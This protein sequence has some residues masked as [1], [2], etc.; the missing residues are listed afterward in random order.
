MTVLVVMIAIAASFAQTTPGLIVQPARNGGEQ[1]LDPN[2]DNY[3]SS[4]STGF[5][6]TSDTGEG[7][8]EIPFRSI[9]TLTA[10]P[11]GDLKNGTAGSHTDFAPPSPLQAFY[12]GTNLIFRL[13]LGGIS[14][15]SRGYSVLIDS[16]NSFSGAG[17]NPG[18]EFEVLL[19]SNFGVSVIQH[20]GTTRQT[21][22]SGAATQFSQKAVAASTGGGD[23]DYFY[24]F[25]VPITA[26]NNLIS[27][28][29]P[30]RM[31]A[32]T[33]NRGQ[34]ALQDVSQVA[35]VAGVDFSRYNQDAPAAWADVIG[36]F[37]PLT[38]NNLVT[39]DIAQ[40]RTFAP[41]LNS[42]ITTAAT[43]IA[44][45][46]RE[47][48]G[49][50][51]QV[52]R[53]G[54]AIGTTTVTSEETWAFALPAGVTLAE[55]NQITA[56]A[57]AA[58]KPVSEAS[59]TVVV[60]GT[61]C[62]TAAPTLS[63]APSSRR[64]RDLTGT[65]APGATVRVYR[66][67]V[68]I[69]NTAGASSVTASST[70]AWTFTVCN[71]ANCISNGLYT[72]TQQVG[73]GCISAPS[74]PL[75][76]VNGRATQQPST[77]APTITTAPVCVGSSNLSGTATA[78]AFVTLF[79]N[80]RPLYLVTT[81]DNAYTVQANAAGA[82]T[83]SGDLGLAAGNTVFARAR[84][85]S[86]YYG[87]S[88]TVTVTSC[89]TTAPVITGEYCGTTTTVTGTS[90]ERAGTTIQIYAD[91]TAVG[92]SGTVNENGFWTVTGLAIPAGT[93]FT[94][95]ATAPG[96]TQSEDSEP[97]TAT[98]QTP[99]T[100]LTI[101]G[102]IQEAATTI[103]GTGPAGAQLTLYIAGTPFTPIVI[104][105]SG[106]WSLS[107]F[108]RSEVFAGAE[109]TATVTAAGQCE[110]EFAEAVVVDCLPLT[111]TFTLSSDSPATL[112]GGSGTVTI[113]LA[114]SQ[115]GVIYTILADG[116]ESGAAVLGTGGPI[117]ITS[118]PIVNETATARE[119]TLRVRASRLVQGTEAPAS[120]SATLDGSITRTILPQVSTDYE[121]VPLTSNIC[122][123]SSVNLQLSSSVSGYTYQ[124]LNEAT[125][126]LV[127]T[128]V[129][130]T[131][132]AISLSTGAVNFNATYAVVI[133][134]NDNGC[135]LTD[136]ARFT[137]VIT[138]PAIDR[139]V[140]ASASSVC[141][142]GPATIN[143]STQANAGYRYDI[144]QI[145]P[146]GVSTQ[147]ANDIEGTGG[148][149]PFTTTRPLD[150]EG[151][152]T[153]YVV[154][155]GGGCGARE[156]LQRASVEVTNAPGVADAGEDQRVCGSE[157]VLAAASPA[158]GTGSWSTVTQPA[159]SPA[160]VFANVNNPATSITGLVSGEYVFRWSVTTTCGGSTSPAVTDEVTITVNCPSTY[161]V[162]PPKYRDEYISGNPLATASD[163]DGGIIA[164]T[165]L[166]GS[167]P[168]GVAF[169][170]TNGNITV[171]EPEL[172]VPGLYEFSVRL[173][174][175]FGD[176]TELTVSILIQ[177]DSPAIVP[178]PVELVY[179]TASVSNGQVQLQWLT[180][181]EQDNDRFEV[182]RSLDAKSFEKIGTVK[183]QGT[184]SVENKY[185]F[186]DRAPAQGTV[187]YR[188]R[189]VDFSGEFAL[190]KVIAV[191]ADG[192]ASNLITEVYPNPF[193]DIL[194]VKL[195]SPDNKAADM[196]IYD[197]NGREVLRK[198]LELETG[199]NNLEL[200]LQQLE[201][202]M[203]ILK[204][205][206]SGLDATTRIMKN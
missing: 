19:N 189:Q 199:V 181:S 173:T 57:T 117:S 51:I 113:N 2:G 43:T 44:G 159:G 147:V 1:I 169:N 185:Q 156:V 120:C 133:T 135:V 41:V 125:G 99:V 174:D 69:T 137:A 176:E 8:S 94:A 155:T 198:A 91:G 184:S 46:S 130:G 186:S 166:S 31:A 143:V 172:L 168:P 89:Q 38:L 164:A 3:V 175:S 85:A 52:L 152:Y 16:D 73:E 93:P 138:G 71:S 7:N 84:T 106:E 17:A 206:G 124:L 183:G 190:S 178:L 177:E 134:N 191:T 145:D 109:I 9:P 20:S 60:T 118:A 4:T 28:T 25:Y 48:E 114:S 97:V 24:D 202:G 68:L 161:V 116:E 87:Q 26:F 128:P 12:D 142:G 105:P 80:G 103:T 18:F 59:N 30:L 64:G 23:P 55:G 101:N 104:P 39:N 139:P 193:P 160:V 131:G 154:V 98:P 110:S 126:E 141:V 36:N 40:I 197:L 90:T 82:W 151:T 200:Q 203:Y 42:P 86:A 21:L 58:G 15:S 204:I 11:L 149:V 5:T 187:Y 34:S 167:I 22:F 146:N 45:T 95:R 33:V 148:V 32:S 136:P 10:E 188:L 66:N 153:Y 150:T 179:F 77:P 70:G 108:A 75:Y 129:A 111:T 170:T 194:K 127:G 29:T 205:V 201:S 171:A 72:A 96:G 102:P 56:N 37:P 162:A 79:L 35:D 47:P 122:A 88:A 63:E 121:V 50:V 92:S 158:P 76:I 112:C 61:A 83:F 107:G 180:A 123:G 192:V 53:N 62:A 67:G 78:N 132:A 14:T 81:A 157:A 65:A 115:L 163:P 27:A 13:R 196:V 100:G 74:A 195:T 54:T 182:E 165:L 49:T 140:F 144:F 119:A 6:G